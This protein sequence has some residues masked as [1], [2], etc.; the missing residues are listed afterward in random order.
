MLGLNSTS[1]PNGGIS[2]FPSSVIIQFLE[3]SRN[4]NLMTICKV[5][6]YAAGN[7]FINIRVIMVMMT[8][9]MF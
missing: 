9:M 2:E 8:I 1:L 4:G 7:A 5:K 3:L 6:L